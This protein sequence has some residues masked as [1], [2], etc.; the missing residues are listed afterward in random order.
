[1]RAFL[2]FIYMGFFYYF[3]CV[4]ILYFW[5][6]EWMYVYLIGVWDA[7]SNNS[8]YYVISVPQTLP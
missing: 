5:C 4:R 7:N 2:M 3:C 1:M 8:L 6:N